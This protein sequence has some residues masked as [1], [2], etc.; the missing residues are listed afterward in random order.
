ML[1]RGKNLSPGDEDVGGADHFEVAAPLAMEPWRP[2]W[3]IGECVLALCAHLSFGSPLPFLLGQRCLA[4]VMATALELMLAFAFWLG[5]IAPGQGIAPCRL[6]P[7][8]CQAPCIILAFAFGFSLLLRA[9][10]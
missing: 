1:V 10:G 8:Q 9:R 5:H 4:L 6:E 3:P 7:C 2:Q